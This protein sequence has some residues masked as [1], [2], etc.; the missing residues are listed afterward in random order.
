MHLVMINSS[1]SFLLYSV[2]SGEALPYLPTM[3]PGAQPNVIRSAFQWALWAPQGPRMAPVGHG[4]TASYQGRGTGT[5]LS[6]RMITG[7]SMCTLAVSVK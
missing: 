6:W 2:D 7:A 3:I 1:F 5:G 4:D